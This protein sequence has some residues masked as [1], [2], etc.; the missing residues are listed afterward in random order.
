MLVQDGFLYL[1]VTR[2]KLTVWATRSTV[3]VQYLELT[4]SFVTDQA[5]AN[6]YL[7]PPGQQDGRLS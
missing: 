3:H 2:H 1:I 4:V 6:N 5:P 7:P